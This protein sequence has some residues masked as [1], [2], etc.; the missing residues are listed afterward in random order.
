MS[1]MQLHMQKRRTYTDQGTKLISITGEEQTVYYLYWGNDSHTKGEYRQLP[2]W[3]N[4]QHTK[5][6]TVTNIR[7]E[8]P[9]ITSM[10]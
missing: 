1:A 9:S 10:G 8:I 3:D 4:E 7:K 6:N 5:G 2:Q